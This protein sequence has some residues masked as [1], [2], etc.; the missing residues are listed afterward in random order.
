MTSVKVKTIP[1]RIVTDRKHIFS[2]MLNDINEMGPIDFIEMFK[3]TREKY[4]TMPLAIKTKTSKIKVPKLSTQTGWL[5][6]SQEFVTDKKVQAFELFTQFDEE[7]QN[8]GKDEKDNG[9]IS[10]KNFKKAI[11]KLGIELTTEVK[12]N[13]RFKKF[14]LTQV[15]RT[16]AG[17]MWKEADKEDYNEKAEEFNTQSIE[18]W[19]NAYE[20]SNGKFTLSTDD[21]VSKIKASGPDSPEVNIKK[22]MKKGDIL[23]IM[24]CV[25]L[26]NEV[27]QCS[28]LDELRNALLEYYKGNCA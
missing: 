2:A 15:L 10:A 11:K 24:G 26:A 20:D 9:T 12:S 25:G 7:E 8:A 4:E 22:N 23:H 28:K 5:L 14:N 6:Y 16:E 19:R 27:T 3:E 1:A 21:V 18:E 13:A 17:R